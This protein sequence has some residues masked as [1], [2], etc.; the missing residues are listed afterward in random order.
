METCNARIETKLKTRVS[1]NKG[2][3]TLAKT[4]VSMVNEFEDAQVAKLPSYFATMLTDFRQMIQKLPSHPGFSNAAVKCVGHGVS[5]SFLA[6]L[7]D[8]ER[9]MG[10]LSPTGVTLVEIAKRD[11]NMN[12]DMVLE[13]ASKTM[14]GRYIMNDSS[15]YCCIYLVSG[16]IAS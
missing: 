8:N 5:R 14:R 3:R 15:K 1:P 16:R 10:A 2:V 7:C 11:L 6:E 12:E 13:A 4:G 9:L